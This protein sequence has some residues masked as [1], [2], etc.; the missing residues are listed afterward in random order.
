MTIP[1]RPL[2]LSRNRDFIKLWAAHAGSAI[3][4]RISRTAFPIIAV[5]VLASS[6][7]HVA[8]LSA[9]SVL[10]AI[11]VGMLFSGR[12]ERAQKQRVMLICDLLRA[13]LLLVVPAAAFFGWLNIWILDAI[14]FLQGAA[15]SAFQIADASFLPVI[16]EASFLVEGNAKFESTDAVAEAAGPGIAGFLIQFLGA[17]GAVL[18]DA[19]SYLWSAFWLGRISRTRHHAEFEQAA[20]ASMLSD[21]VTGWRTCVSTPLLAAMLTI[22][23]LTSLSN[24]FFMALYM[25]LALR[26]LGLS[27]GVIGLI[28]SVGGISSLIAAVL[29]PALTRRFAL[30]P[31]LASCLVLGQGAD[32]LIAMAPSTGSFAPALLV[33]QQLLGDGFCTLYAIYALA[34]RQRLLEVGVLAR[35]HATFQ[36]ASGVAMPLGA[37]IAGVTATYLGIQTAMVIAGAIGV[38][39][40]LTLLPANQAGHSAKS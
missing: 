11:L 37:L 40:A 21:I 23:V 19:A 4:S 31:L 38:A 39:S 28:V 5:L 9:V 22:E 2:T 26:Q 10:P 33:G 14:A 35:S 7:E 8:F 18:L 12:I 27:P 30:L 16:V 17:P 3:G 6:T 20:P 25:L 1:G 29:A 32:F 24:G 34:A 15:T 13:G 36:I